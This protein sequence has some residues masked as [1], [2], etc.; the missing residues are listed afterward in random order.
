LGR[1][2]PK[3]S[4]LR[5]DFLLLLSAVSGSLPKQGGLGWVSGWGGSS[6]SSS[7][8]LSLRLMIVSLC[9]L[10]REYPLVVKLI[11]FALFSE[12]GKLKVA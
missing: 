12:K 7:L 9:L 1:D 5:E 2:P 4:L 6:L 11:N 8:S 3:S 10:K